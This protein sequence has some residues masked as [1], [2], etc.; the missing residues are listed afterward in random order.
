MNL[1]FGVPALAGPDRLKAGHQTCDTPD[2]GSWSQCIRKN[3]RQLP[4][5]HIDRNGYS[6]KAS[7]EA[8]IAVPRSRESVEGHLNFACRS[9]S[10]RGT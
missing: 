4:L 5:L 7:N 3:E 2:S 8:L 6:T 1:P 9:S 10:S